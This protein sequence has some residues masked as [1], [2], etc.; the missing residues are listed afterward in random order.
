MQ[1]K[2]GIAYLARPI[3][4]LTCS[5]GEYE[6]IALIRLTNMYYA[7]S[8][9]QSCILPR[10]RYSDSSNNLDLLQHQPHIET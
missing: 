6:S 10:G 4:A 5:A 7:V 2:A 9:A 3:G 1:V 8:Y